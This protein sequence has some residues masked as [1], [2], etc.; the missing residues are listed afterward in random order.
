[1]AF[2]LSS[3]QKQNKPQK[4]KL[5]FDDANKLL[6]SA[7]I[8]F[9]FFAPLAT[10][11]KPPW[12]CWSLSFSSPPEGVCLICLWLQILEQTTRKP[13]KCSVTTAPA[14]GLGFI[15]S[16]PIGFS[17]NLLNMHSLSRQN[18][19]AADRSQGSFQLRR[20]H[21]LNA[22]EAWWGH[23]AWRLQAFP[24]L[25][26]TRWYIPMWV[27]V[28]LPAGGVGIANYIGS[29]LL[30]RVFVFVGLGGIIDTTSQTDEWWAHKWKMTV[31]LNAI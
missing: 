16:I 9:R 24:S 18:D 28:L 14:E 21:R 26:S 4:Q 22:N 23:I 8:L 20:C 13:G 7:Q 30:S 31:C 10:E 6:T 1:M 29:A 27:L 17:W 5:L 3:W 11:W 15:A 19:Q 12:H 2:L 25:R